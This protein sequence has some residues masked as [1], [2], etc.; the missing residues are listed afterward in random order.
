[1]RHRLATLREEQG[2]N[3]PTAKLSSVDF[4]SRSGSSAARQVGI[5]GA[6]VLV[7]VFVRGTPCMGAV[8][9][10]ALEALREGRR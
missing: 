2:A 4:V 6:R 1:M 7:V 5:A 10:R 3:G 9:M 8:W